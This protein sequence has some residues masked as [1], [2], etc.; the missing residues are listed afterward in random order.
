MSLTIEVEDIY[1]INGLSRRGEVANL[2]SCGGPGGG[3]TINEYIAVYFYPD[4]DK[5]GSQVPTNAIQVLGLKAIVLTLG[6]IAGLA[7]LHQASRPLMFYT[8]EYMRPTIYDWSTT[9]L[10]NMKHQLSE[11]KAG[12]V[13]NFGFSSILS[14][15]FFERVPGLSPRVDV[16]LHGVRDPAQR[17]WEGGQPLSS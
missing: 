10:S 8:M 14:M 12:R 6:S 13:Q 15:F 1:F 5:V 4:T 17:R 16:P 11:C 3:L 9:L 7:S 2:H